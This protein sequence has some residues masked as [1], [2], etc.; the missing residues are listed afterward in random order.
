MTSWCQHD[1]NIVLTQCYAR[2]LVVSLL[3]PVAWS[4]PPHAVG[5]LH[6]SRPPPRHQLIEP[7]AAP[8]H[9]HP[10][11]MSP[12]CDVIA[13]CHSA[14]EKMHWSCPSR[15]AWRHLCA[16]ATKILTFQHSTKAM[17]V[18]FIGLELNAL[19]VCNLPRLPGSPHTARHG[20]PCFE[21]NLNLSPGS[22]CAAP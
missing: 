4:P 15:I 11:G 1:L 7:P 18:V 6:C 3:L 22:K 20:L 16:S 12:S 13:H 5:S 10:H 14:F 2:Y 17:V 9:S 8:R 19:R 21:S